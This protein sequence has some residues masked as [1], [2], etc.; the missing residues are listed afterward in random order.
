MLTSALL[1]RS[2]RSKPSKQNQW[3]LSGAAITLMDDVHGR[4]RAGA[5][6]RGVSA[7]G[8]SQPAEQRPLWVESRNSN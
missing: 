3:L 7:F 5:G 6:P 1:S 4:V 2:D 8:T